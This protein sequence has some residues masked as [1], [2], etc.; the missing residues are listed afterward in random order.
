MGHPNDGYLCNGGLC[1][2]TLRNSSFSACPGTFLQDREFWV[3]V[4]LAR[5]G[6]QDSLDNF[7]LNL[8]CSNIGQGGIDYTT[9]DAQLKGNM[10]FIRDGIVKHTTT[11]FRFF[12]LFKGAATPRVRP[13]PSKPYERRPFIASP[14]W[15]DEGMLY[16]IY[17]KFSSLSASTHQALSPFVPWC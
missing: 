10:K 5:D 9:P 7:V 6:P 1:N 3:G 11:D 12:N 17:C 2:I 13:E 8:Y 16:I 14:V 4:A 15:A